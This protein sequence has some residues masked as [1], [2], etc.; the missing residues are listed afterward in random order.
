MMLA[1]DDTIGALIDRLKANGQLE[2]T[3]IFFFSMTTEP[4]PRGLFIK[5]D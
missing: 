5:V 1:L 4:M 2:N 3:I